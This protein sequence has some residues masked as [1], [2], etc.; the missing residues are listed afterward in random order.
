MR[1][2]DLVAMASDAS[3]SCGGGAVEEVEA[4]VVE[5]EREEEEELGVVGG[6][7]LAG[8]SPA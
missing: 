4:V 5:E 3:M 2:S 1:E 7:R 6:L 8:E